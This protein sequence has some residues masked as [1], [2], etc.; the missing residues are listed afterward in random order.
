MGDRRLQALGVPLKRLKQ[1][2]A[3]GY[4]EPIPKTFP[5]SRCVRAAIQQ[6]FIELKG[7]NKQ[8]LNQI[9][10]KIKF[11]DGVVTKRMSDYATSCTSLTMVDMTTKWAFKM[12]LSSAKSLTA[13]MM[14]RDS[15]GST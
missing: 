6:G 5:V 13:L 12:P 11:T 3:M 15:T 7:E 14:R 2:G 8:E 9:I 4:G 1:K 10:A